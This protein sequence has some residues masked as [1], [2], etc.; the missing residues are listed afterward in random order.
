[1]STEDEEQQTV[2]RQL[3]WM[4]ATGPEAVAALLADAAEW[5]RDNTNW[6]YDLSLAADEEGTS[7]SVYCELLPEEGEGVAEEE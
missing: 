4:S 5:I 7:I 2:S 3:F 1:M 6:V